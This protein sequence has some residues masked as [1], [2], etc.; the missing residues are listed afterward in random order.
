M[1]SVKDF[2]RRVYSFMRRHTLAST[3]AIGVSGYYLYKYLS[4]KTPE[5]QL[6]YFISALKS[7]SLEQVVVNGDFAY[8]KP[9]NL[10]QWYLT[11]IKMITKDQLFKIL[12]NN[13][14]LHVTSEGS[15]QKEILTLISTGSLLYYFALKQ[16]LPKQAD[17]T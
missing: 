11:N 5:I 1:E 13:P 15:R 3:L 9:I 12:F 4:H 6:S 17:V 16:L 14:A 10:N 7:N 8:F 2:F